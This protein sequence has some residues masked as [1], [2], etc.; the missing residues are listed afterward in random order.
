MVSDKNDVIIFLKTLLLVKENSC[1]TVLLTSTGGRKVMVGGWY[2]NTLD[3]G[4]NDDDVKL[5]LTFGISLYLN[6]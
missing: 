3:M 1:K 6:M 2:Y 5:A 4:L